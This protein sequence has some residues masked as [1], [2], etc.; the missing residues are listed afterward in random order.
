MPIAGENTSPLGYL[1]NIDLSADAETAYE[2]ELETGTKRWYLT[3]LVYADANGDLSG[4]TAVFNIGTAPGEDQIAS[5]GDPTLLTSAGIVIPEPQVVANATPEALTADKL[6]L[7]IG[8]P[9]AE[10]ETLS[11]Y[12]FGNYL[13]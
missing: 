6:Y 2:I 7:T 11:V 9:G 1:K 10:G 3:A 4:S 8:T 13:P 5:N 12:V